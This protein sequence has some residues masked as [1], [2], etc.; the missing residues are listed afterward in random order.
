ML[1]NSIHFIFFFFVTIIIGNLLRSRKQKLFF[2]LASYYFYMAWNPAFII[3]IL[4]STVLDYLVGLNLMNP[5][6]GERRRKMLLVLSMVG[7]L[8]LLCFFKYTNFFMGVFY[9]VCH[10]IADSGIVFFLQNTSLFL[11]QSHQIIYGNDLAY[12]SLAPAPKYD[13]TLPVGISFYTFQ[14]MSYTIDVYRKDLEARESFV[15]FALYVAFFPQLVAGPI[16]RATTFLRDLDKRL[17]VTNEDVQVAIS[18]ILIGFMRKLVFADNLAIVVN[19]TFAN[20]AVMNPW[21][22][23][24]GAIAFCWQIYFDFAGYTDIAIG[25]ARLFGFKFDANFNF[26]MSCSNIVDHWTKWHISFS[27]W[28]R[29]YIFIP[30]GGSRGSTWIT[31]RNITI[32]W[33]FGG[34]WHGAAYHFVSWGLWQAVMI[35]VYREY[36]KTR[37]R[38]WFFERGGRVYDIWSRIFTMFCLSFGFVM[39]RAETMQKTWEMIR[40]MLFIDLKNGQ[41]ILIRYSTSHYGLLL[42]L[43]FTASYIFS[44]RN[45]EFM[46]KKSHG[47]VYT[48]TIS[49][50][51]IIIFGVTDTQKFLYFDF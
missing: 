25:V 2:L 38:A 10:L 51:L 9:D 40:T 20:Y 35:I 29:D 12:L 48:N 19:K 31:Y 3:L 45:I 39:F 43:C 50:F 6:Y 32:T 34:A 36:A 27:T 21:E 11:D 46:A 4:S 17:P 37:L 47:L 33:L 16:V 23:W 13:I 8:G 22:I 24:T 18:R 14:S 28:I 26:P 15:D 1:F 44:K 7:N 42:V 41:E 49:I 5:N 30:L